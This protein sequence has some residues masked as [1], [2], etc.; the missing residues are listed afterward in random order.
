MAKITYEDKEF[1]NKN[2]NIADKNKVNDT[3]LNEIK[4]V[5]NE[6]D[7][8]VGDLLNLNTTDKSSLVGAINELN[9]KNLKKLWENSN[10]KNNFIA[11]NITLSSDDYDYLIWFYYDD[12]GNNYS[13]SRQNLKGSGTVFNHAFSGSVTNISRTIVRVSDT[14]YNIHECM[15]VTT[16][17]TTTTN[18]RLIPAVVYGGKF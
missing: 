2:E 18:N 14:N 13:M 16:S 12:T 6:N 8:N 3:D 11:Q 17:G 1:L 5:I 10:P 9:N 4:E 15:S 7:D